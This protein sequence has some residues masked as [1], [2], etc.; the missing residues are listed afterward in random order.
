[1]NPYKLAKKDP[2]EFMGL[3]PHGSGINA[4]W[5]YEEKKGHIDFF[6]AFHVMN[7]VGYYVGWCEF[8]I[9]LYPN[10]SWRLSFYGPTRWKARYYYLRDFLEEEFGYFFEKIRQGKIS[11]ERRE[12]GC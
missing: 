8:Y 9:R 3:L 5:G 7:D 10:G 6:N 2:K 4:D 1:M 11:Q 12:D